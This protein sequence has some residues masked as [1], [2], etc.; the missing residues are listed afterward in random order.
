MTSTYLAGL[1]DDGRRISIHWLLDALLL[2]LFTLLA[3]PL[4]HA[5][6]PEIECHQI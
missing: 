3:L 2:P 5:D 6:E 4:L 1:V